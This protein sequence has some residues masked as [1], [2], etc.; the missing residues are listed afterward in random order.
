M[1]TTLIVSLPPI[2]IPFEKSD[3]YII[4]HLQTESSGNVDKKIADKPHGSKHQ[5]RSA[6]KKT[7]LLLEYISLKANLYLP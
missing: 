6:I 5:Q 3:G 1:L 7:A 4:E 2:Y